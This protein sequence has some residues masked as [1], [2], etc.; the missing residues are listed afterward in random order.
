MTENRL[1]GESRKKGN[2]M[3]QAS[4]KSRARCEDRKGGGIEKRSKRKRHRLREREEGKRIIAEG[5]NGWC[6][7]AFSV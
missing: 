4:K 1:A 3:G 6:E 2:M 7:R 5:E